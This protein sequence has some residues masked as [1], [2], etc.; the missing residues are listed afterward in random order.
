MPQTDEPPM[1]SFSLKRTTGNARGRGAGRKG[2]DGGRLG[3]LLSGL[4]LGSSIAVCG[5]GVG[6]QGQEG[7]DAQERPS[8]VALQRSAQRHAAREGQ[9]AQPAGRPNI[10]FYIVDDQARDR[11]NLLPEGRDAAGEPRNHTPTLDRLAREGLVLDQMHVPSPVCIPSRFAILTG[12][13]GSR[14]ESFNIQARF[15]LHGFPPTGQNTLILPGRTVTLAD[16]LREAGY[17][18]GVVGKNHVVEVEGYDKGAWDDDIDDPQVAL[19][20]RENQEKLRQAFRDSGFDYAQRLYHDNLPPNAPHALL[21]HN[22]DWVTE[23]A[24]EFIEESAAG[25]RPFFLYFG[26]TVPHTPDAPPQTY[27]ADRRITPGGMLDQPVELLKSGQQIQQE[28]ADHG[29]DDPMRGNALWIDS[30]VQVIHD[31]LAELGLADNTIFVYFNDHGVEAGKTSVY[32]GGMVTYCFVS[33]AEPWVRGGRRS[34]ALLSSVDWATTILSWAGA[35]PAR[36][37]DQLDGLSFAPLVAGQMPQ[38]RHSV[39]GEIGYSRSVRI[40]DWKYI[41]LRPA[42]YITDMSLEDRG[43]ILQ[44]WFDR[45]DRMGIRR[46][47]NEPTD[48]F[49]HI[50]DIPGGVDNTWGPMRKHPHYF[51][52]EQLYNLA[53][54]PDEQV[55]LALDPAYAAVRETL[56]IELSRY[57]ERLPGRFGEFPG[58][59]GEPRVKPEDAGLNP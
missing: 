54:D 45:R 13:Y 20:L 37:A 25:D 41:A 53:E 50:M 26:S 48:P 11:M 30:S 49:P 47:P 55:N 3:R 14:A 28:L 16:R 35:D 10:I 6:A 56:R 1:I 31:K 4:I 43:A 27:L 12:Q 58:A 19:R 36:Y 7:V 18:T 9:R 51:D 2:F 23:G 42:S 21:A 33:G 17:T 52:A 34:D 57:L 44:R 32:Q 5:G 24:L 29:I 22:L 39:Y 8:I 15:A 40:G 38:T 59:G 46:E